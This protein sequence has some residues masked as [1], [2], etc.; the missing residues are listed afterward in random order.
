[1]LEI[2]QQ[3]KGKTAVITGGSGVLCG[4]MARELG[5]Q[6]MK[7]AIL[8]RNAENGELVAADIQKAG[9]EAIAVECDVLDQKSVERAERLVAQRFGGCDLLINGAGGNHPNG[10]TSNETLHPD[11]LLNENITTLFDLHTADVR[12]VFNLNFLGSF[13]PTQIFTKKMLNR[14]GASVINI[15]SMSAK[16]PMTKVP[17]Y[18]AAKAGIEN[19]TKWLAVY[20]AETGIRVNA[21]APGFFLTKQNERLLLDQNGGLTERAES[22]ISHT[23]M[24][25]FGRPEDLLGTLLWLAD[26]EMSG[27]VTG[28]TVPVDGGF[29]AY[30]GV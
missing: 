20:L 21:I 23:P 11:H 12:S 29:L 8:N 28:I 27:F 9:G 19:F 15:S 22:I 24:K 13:I 26:E 25:R 3:L 1:M 14:K 5:R 30:S 2:H 16:V 6:G 7:V 17:A 18:S 4:A 10:T